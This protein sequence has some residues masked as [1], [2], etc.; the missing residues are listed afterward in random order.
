MAFI[1]NDETGQQLLVTSCWSES[2]VRTFADKM[3]VYLNGEQVAT[4]MKRLCR[5]ANH[6]NHKTIDWQVVVQMID[7]V[8]AESID[9]SDDEILAIA[10]MYLYD[11]GKNYSIIQFGRAIEARVKDD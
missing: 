5:I 7:H 9:L 8:K 10:D 11:S 4:V 2:D 1:M 3:G 6:N